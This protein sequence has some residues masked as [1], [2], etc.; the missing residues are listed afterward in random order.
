MY[1]SFFFLNI[2]L[3]LLSK[4]D[5]GQEEPLHVFFNLEKK[6]NKFKKRRKNKNKIE[7]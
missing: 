3:L 4:S 1:T 2:L 6:L 5:I 7:K